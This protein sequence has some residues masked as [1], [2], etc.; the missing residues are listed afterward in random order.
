MGLGPKWESWLHAEHPPTCLTDS[1]VHAFDHRGQ[2]CEH[3]WLSLL[4]KS[5]R[6][7]VL[8]TGVIDLNLV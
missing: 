8:L 6:A 7:H 2:K 5:L 1:E 3:G 4:E